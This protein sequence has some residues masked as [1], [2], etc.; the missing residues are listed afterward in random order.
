MFINTSLKKS[1]GFSAILNPNSSPNLLASSWSILPA[2]LRV[3]PIKL[4][5]VLV[6][7]KINKIK[8]GNS[9]RMESKVLVTSVVPEIV[10]KN[11]KYFLI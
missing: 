3:N 11:L 6:H 9:I 1:D 2:S 4:R 8:S 7:Q 10:P 5:K